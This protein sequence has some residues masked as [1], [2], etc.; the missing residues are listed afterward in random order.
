[1]PDNFDEEDWAVDLYSGPVETAVLNGAFP[2]EFEAE[3][4]DTE[5]S[6]IDSEYYEVAWTRDQ[7][8]LPKE[9]ADGLF[10]AF[11]PKAIYQEA[12]GDIGEPPDDFAEICA[13]L[14]IERRDEPDD[15]K[16]HPNW[17]CWLEVTK[18]TF[19]R[20]QLDEDDEDLYDYD[21]QDDVS[22]IEISQELGDPNESIAQKLED[23]LSAFEAKGADGI[24]KSMQAALTREEIERRTSWFPASLPQPIIELYEW[25]N[26]QA[27][28]PWGEPHPF[29]F[30]D[31][32]FLSLENAAT[33]YE[34]MMSSYGINN[35]LEDDGIEL[36]TSFPIAAF[37]GGW[38][39]VPVGEHNFGSDTPQPVVCVLEGIDM[40]FHSIPKMLDT[41][42]EW[43][44]TSSYDYADGELTEHEEM[45]IWVKHN[46]G[47]DGDE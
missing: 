10:I 45:A 3:A 14:T 13:K 38:Y 12:F 33:E 31:M 18:A 29:V 41:C 43:V 4:I 37:N 28:D 19:L 6:D 46:P 7:P 26:G 27:S 42:N 24:R 17:K 11:I 44:R 25:A 9:E 39:V 23:L 36:A 15:K 20:W 30:R 35:T 22:P 47:I 40:H 34:S 2:Q 16:S 5:P 8:G 32:G 21:E 1:M